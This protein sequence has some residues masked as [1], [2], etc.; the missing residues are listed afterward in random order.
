MT[1]T[2]VPSPKEMRLSEYALS[3]FIFRRDLRVEDN[4]ALLAASQASQKVMVCFFLDPQQLQRNPYRGEPSLSFMRDSLMELEKRVGDLGGKLHFFYGP[5][6]KILAKI[7]RQVPFQALFLNRDYT[8]FSRKRDKS[9]EHVCAKWK[10][11]F[12]LCDDSLLHAPEETVKKDGSPYSVFTPFFRNASL[13]P[14]RQPAKS[15]KRILTR[16]KIEGEKKGWKTLLKTSF[17]NGQKGGRKNGLGRL[18]QLNT[19]KNYAN[20]HDI[21]SLH[22]SR[23]AAHLKFGTLSIRETYESIVRK[24]GK[25]HPLVR[26]LYWRDFFTSIAFQ[27]PR[28]FGSAFHEKY[29]AV[30]WM[31]DQAAFKRWCEGRTGF[32]IVDAGMRELRRT[33]FMH[34]R[35]RMITASFL[36][37]DLHVDWRWGERYF[38]K[39]LTD[40]DPSVNNGN[41]QWAASTGCDAQPYFRIFNPWRQ[42]VRF[43][44]ECLYIKKW[45]PEL[46]P[47]PASRIHGWEKKHDMKEGDYPAPMCDHS[48]ESARALIMYRR[49]FS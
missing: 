8:P 45:I 17:S 25:N 42:Q 48:K 10:I 1:G 41:W 27:F 12:H 32:P 23:L 46:S 2:G 19:L 22:T 49:V 13:I 4:T 18:H 36:V 44:P 6:E 47:W 31:K 21:P 35:V 5:P 9:L 40:Y 43:D 26:Q 20:T 24:L 30:P 11:D 34:N 7:R 29:D 33:G 38:A 28:V 3:L 14:V 16:F 39:W 37:K 15:P